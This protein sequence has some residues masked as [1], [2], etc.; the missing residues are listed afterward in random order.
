MFLRYIHNFRAIAILFIIAGHCTWGL[1]WGNYKYPLFKNLFV[2]IFMNGTVLFVFIAGFLFQHLSSKFSFKK[3]LSKKFKFVILPYILCSIPAIGVKLSLS[4]SIPLEV[5]VWLNDAFG[6]WPAVIHFVLYLKQILWYLV[7]GDSL[8]PFW[9]IPMISIFYILAPLLI[10]IDKRHKIYRLLPAFIAISII[11]PRPYDTTQILHSFPHFF[12]VYLFGMFCSHYKE[13]LIAKTE[14]IWVYLFFSI[15]ALIEMEM[16]YPTRQLGYSSYNYIQKMLLCVLL[17]Y[18]LRRIDILVPEGIGSWGNILANLSFGIY[19]IHYYLLY[20]VR[21]ASYFNFLQ[22]SLHS[23]LILFIC[24][25]MLSVVSL[26]V[27]KSF[28]RNRSRIFIGC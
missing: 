9:F 8:T 10:Y 22:G 2:I 27:A 20:A 21:E 11:I 5:P 16:L 24:T 4:R 18:W 25:T 28:L 3:Y 12:S 6:N 17:V 13:P 23:L 15:L 1:T 14:K 7:S 26:R 19:F